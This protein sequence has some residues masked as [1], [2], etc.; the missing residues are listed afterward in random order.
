MGF[1]YPNMRASCFDDSREMLLA[2]DRANARVFDD[3]L[4]RISSR[5]GTDGLVGARNDV[6]RT[7]LDSDVDWLLWIDSDMGF[8]PDAAYRLLACAD[9]VER[10]I[11]GGLCFVNREYAFDGKHGFWTRPQPAIFDYRHDENGVLKF[12]SNP[13]YP[14]NTLVQCKAT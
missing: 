13:L 3:S 11:V 14:V 12:L 8:A 10:P 9:P 4:G 6:V 1:V 5:V 2:H 7:L